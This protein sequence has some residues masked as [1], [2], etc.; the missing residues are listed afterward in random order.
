MAG[1]IKGITI[2]IEGKTSGL[3]KSLNEAN[4][5]ISSSNKALRELDKALKIDPKNVEILA[6][7][8]EILTDAI[9]ATKQKLE[10]EKQVAEDAKQA[11][12]EGTITKD[13]YAALQ[14]EVVKTTDALQQLEAE[15]ANTQAAMDAAADPSIWDAV[16]QK[17][18]EVGNTMQAVGDTMQQIGDK[19]SD[20]GDKLTTGVTVPLAAFGKASADAFHEVDAGM[21]IVT[22][23]TGATGE[24]L[25]QMHQIAKDM[26]TDIPTDFETAGAAVGEVNTRF[27]L[28]G[29]ELSDLSTQFVKF[30][31]LNNT[32]VSSSIDK[33]QKVMAAYG[34]KTKDA[35][36]LLDTLNATG[37]KTGISMDSL[38]STMVTNSGQLQQ[39]GFNAAEAAQFLGQLEVSG[40]DASQVMTGLTKA[41]KTASDEGKPMNEALEEIQTNMANATSDAEGLNYAYELFGS[42]AGAAIYTAC[43][44]GS[45]SFENLSASINDNL[46]SVNET[47]DN[48]IDGMDNMTT[49][50]NA[51]KE[52]L[53]EVGKSLGDTLAPILKQ[54]A[55]VLKTLAEKWKSLSP[56]MQSFIVKAGLVVGVL[57][58]VFSIVG[59]IISGIGGLISIIGAVVSFVGGTVIPFITAT[60][61]PAISAVGAPIL[62]VIAVITAVITVIKNWG[63]ICEVFQAIWEGLRDAVIDIA[64]NIKDKVVGAFNAVK[65]GITSA[66]EG[67]KTWLTNTWTTIKDTVVEKV[68][69]IKD[70]IVNGFHNAIDGVK[71]K[72][73][74]IRDAIEEKIQEALDWIKE[75]PSKLYQWG[76]DMMKGLADGIKSAAS[77]VTNAVS[78][79]CDKIRSMMHFSRP[80]EGPLRD[81]ETWM[82]DMLRGLANSLKENV[83]ILNP[84][85][86]VVSGTLAT[87]IAGPDYT[88]QLTSIQNTLA[89][90]GGGDLIVPV[91]I[92]QDRFATAVVKANQMTNYRSG[93]R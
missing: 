45:V 56:Q 7:K 24:A 90:S 9:E 36:K 48:T 73:G 81:Y 3:V 62:A 32:D 53:S 69:A 46:G 34:I 91:Y 55:D 19:V 27:G 67:A 6:T 80:D 79:P 50:G 93:G 92:G 70:G 26:A 18:E 28:M 29:E 15:A 42:R 66:I 43:K 2:E 39:M 75:L 74:Q 40:V 47:Y 20:V 13:Q 60:V 85:L 82:P 89:Q 31:S 17:V 23:K 8:Q 33:V 84:A 49:A 68:T 86:D 61:I 21:D 41:L 16:A 65:D 12:E 71:E 5:T 58:P 63:A 88:S 25:E 30:S 64:N 4:K 54:V 78:K 77:L 59:R 76:A 72:V 52:A 1:S 14:A 38:M 22:Q 87:G 37:Q 11:L 44:N 35:A 10:A 51:M 83:G 57:G